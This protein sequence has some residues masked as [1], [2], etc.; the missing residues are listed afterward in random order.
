MPTNQCW[1]L[2]LLEHIGVP[3]E[4]KKQ[5]HGESLEII[6]LVVDL[7][8]M[9]ISMS[10]G[11]KHSLIEA[12]HDFI[13]NTPGNKHQQPLRAWL[14][15]LGHANWALNAFPI[16]KP[17]LNSSYDKISGKTAL[18]QGVYVN[19]CVHEDLLWFAH[20]VGHLDGIRLFEAEEWSADEANLEIWSDASKDGLGFW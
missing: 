20:S 9:T 12:I 16:L 1:F 13:L 3:H 4:D 7:R 6:G 19:K 15:I 10:T 14:R 2:H 5:L 17:A 18:S 8:D 11:A